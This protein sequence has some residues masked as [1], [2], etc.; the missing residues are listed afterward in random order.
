MLSGKTKSKPN[1]FLL[2]DQT[3]DFTYSFEK[4]NDYWHRNQQEQGHR[5]R[6]QYRERLT[7]SSVETFGQD[8][9][10]QGFL[11]QGDVFDLYR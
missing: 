2:P 5:R 3:F 4:K 11:K 6:H 10:W 8:R 7:Q 9:D 1:C